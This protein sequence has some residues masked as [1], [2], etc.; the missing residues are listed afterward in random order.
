[1]KVIILFI[2]FLSL[3]A[4]ASTEMRDES[5]QIG[6]RGFRDTSSLKEREAKQKLLKKQ[7]E[8]RRQKAKLRKK[9][10]TVARPMNVRKTAVGSSLSGLVLGPDK[11][12]IYNNLGLYSGDKLRLE[13]NEDMIGYTGSVRS[14]SARVLNDD[15]KGYKAL[16][17]VSMDP[18]TKE[19]IITISKVVSPSGTNSHNLKAELRIK[20]R[21]ESKFWNYF[22]ASVAANAVGGLAEASKTRE[23]TIFGS[24]KAVTPGNILKGSIAG[25]LEG[26]A[27]VLAKELKNYPEFTV[28][29][30]PVIDSATISEEPNTF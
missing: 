27:N 17:N 3:C 29:L 24:Q 5:W 30:G 16:G 22:W 12:S 1:M 19:L 14:I 18:R 13:I 11:G 2:T 26:G 6:K 15:L 25:G 8:L 21:H 28:V 20:G 9:S 7:M 4:M 23:A 10:K